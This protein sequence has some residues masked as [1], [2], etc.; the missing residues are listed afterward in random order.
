MSLVIIIS[1]RLRLD[2]AAL[3]AAPQIV[4]PGA[5]IAGRADRM[6][7]RDMANISILSAKDVGESHHPFR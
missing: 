4:A 6:P 3:M 2:Q 7:M 1:F 5:R